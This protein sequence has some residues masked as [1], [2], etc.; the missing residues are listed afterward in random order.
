MAASLEAI[1]MS[2]NVTLIDAGKHLNRLFLVKGEES[3]SP[4]M[5]TGSLGGATTV[6]GGQVGIML[7]EDFNRWESLADYSKEDAL[8][9]SSLAEVLIEELNIPKHLY[10]RKNSKPRKRER[11]ILRRTSYLPEPKLDK[12]KQELLESPNF[13][14]IDNIQ[15]D[16]LEVF[17]GKVKTIVLTN[18]KRLHL[19]DIPCV[20]AAGTI[21]TTL[22]LLKSEVNEHLQIESDDKNYIGKN[23]SDH[24]HLV[25]GQYH[26]RGFA[27]IPANL[28]IE[29]NEKYKSKNIFTVEASDKIKYFAN[30]EMHKITE[31]LDF[32]PNLRTIQVVLKKV[33]E[34][35]CQVIL[36]KKISTFL[37]PTRYQVWLQI[38]QANNPESSIKFENQNIINNYQISGI[39]HEVVLRVQSEIESLLGK[40][41][42][43]PNPLRTLNQFMSFIQ[44]AAH[45]SGTIRMHKDPQKGIVDCDGIFF[46]IGNLGVASS[47]IFPSSGWINP[48]LMIMAQAKRVTRQLLLSEKVN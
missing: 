16:K 6:W 43:S 4:S 13:N 22:L 9:L 3:N 36:S 14:F 30:V 8:T 32:N 46:K 11:I 34:K 44:E 45:P 5:E 31:N 26:K 10:Y 39:D 17:E 33:S 48:T 1:R 20:L 41:N 25:I 18:G 28:S 12:F 42:F 47:A 23:L 35:L 40:W 37:F 19:N 15:V 29:V 24:P 27:R 21:G 38:E 2:R 7:R